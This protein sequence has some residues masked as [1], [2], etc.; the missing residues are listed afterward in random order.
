MTAGEDMTLR[1]WQLPPVAGVAPV[2]GDGNDAGLG[3]PLD[4]NRK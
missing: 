2:A 1:Y 3:I 4:K